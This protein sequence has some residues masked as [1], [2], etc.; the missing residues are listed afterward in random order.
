MIPV[1]RFEGAEPP[2]FVGLEFEHGRR[3]R[4]AEVAGD[5]I[6]G[7]LDVV[8]VVQETLTVA[9]AFGKRHVRVVEFGELGFGKL[10]R[11]LPAVA[12]VAEIDVRERRVGID[13]IVV[14]VRFVILRDLF[15]GHVDRRRHEAVGNEL[16]R[17]DQPLLDDV[18][19]L[20]HAQ[21]QGFPV[22]G[23]FAHVVVDQHRQLGIAQGIEPR[24]CHFRVERLRAELH[25]RE[26]RIAIDDD[27][28]AVDI[29]VFRRDQV[30]EN[31][32][33]CADRQEVDQGFPQQLF[34]NASPTPK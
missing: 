23:F 20:V 31:E 5:E 17:L 15:V 4:P 30:E 1:R 2:A 28:L 33:A 6:L 14:P 29:A 27:R 25:E 26:Q 12:V 32:E 13:V 7:A 19:V 3:H 18:V 24:R 22:Q 21:R 8:D 16:Q 11:L 10:A 9:R 34:Q